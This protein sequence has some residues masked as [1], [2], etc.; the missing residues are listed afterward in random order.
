MQKLLDQFSQKSVD[1]WNLGQWEKPLD[2]GSNLDH[3]ILTVRIRV[4]L[5]FQLGCGTTMLRL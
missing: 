4:G 3:V 1:R 2:F 5:E